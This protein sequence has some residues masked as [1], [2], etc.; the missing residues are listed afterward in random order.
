M[1]TTEVGGTDCNLPC[2]KFVDVVKRLLK[3][4][5]EKDRFFQSVFPEEFGPA[6]DEA[7]HALIWLF[8][9]RLEKFVPYQTFQQFACVLG[10][11]PSVLE[12][13]VQSV[14][15]CEELRS[16]LQYQRNLI[17]LDHHD[18]VSDGACIISALKLPPVRPSPQIQGQ[19]LWLEDFQLHMSNLDKKSVSVPHKAP[20][21]PAIASEL[22]TSESG[23]DACIC[24]P[25]QQ[26]CSGN[27]KIEQTQ[28]N[29]QSEDTLQCALKECKIQL[30]RIDTPQFR[31][32]HPV[33]P[34]R[35]LKMKLLL[36]EEK[37][38]LEDEQGQASGTT[39]GDEAEEES[40]NVD[41]MSPCSEDSWSIYSDQNS[42]DKS[43]R[44]RSSTADSSWSYYS[45]DDSSFVSPASPC[46]SEDHFRD[47]KKTS[48]TSRKPELPNN[49]F[50]ASKKTRRFHCFI[51]N[52]TLTTKLETHLKTHFPSGDYACPHCDA[53]FHLYRGLQKHLKSA[54]YNFYSYKISQDTPEKPGD[55]YKCNEC[56]HAF[57]YKVSLQRHVRTHHELYCAVCQ[58]VLR[59]A[60]AL[61]RHKVSHM[62]FQ[63]NHCSQSFTL[64]KHLLKH[65]ENVHKFKKPYQCYRCSMTVASIRRLII[66]EWKHTGHL[67]FQCTQCGLRCRSDAD[68]IDHSRVHTRERPYLCAECGKTFSQRTNM[69][70]HF[71][72]IHGESR[73][74]R[75]HACSQCEKSFKE[76]GS[77]KKHQRTKHLKELF[78]NPCPYCGKMISTSTMARHKL[79]HTG[80]KP[81]KCDQ[82]DKAFRSNPE[83]KKHKLMCHTLERPYKCDVCGKG[84]IKMWCLKQHTKIHSGE[85]PFVCNICGRAF[86]KCSSMVRHKRLLHTFKVQ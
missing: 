77:L 9:S 3:D 24:E 31:P 76:K 78:H 15:Q 48:A 33:R 82:C 63:C 5:A 61:A 28:N 17:T 71:N 72:L 34:N 41:F 68:L 29:V 40:D 53:R 42:G 73:N 4:P 81:F 12:E 44:S 43:F 32:S 84:F 8:L 57:K 55:I 37:R 26:L 67:P 60:E 80:E 62:P 19:D 85:K 56:T 58:K 16:L 14:S 27:I 18:L 21:T 65:C 10:E 23:M 38:L 54:C 70:R 11:A 25:E 50:P 83:V 52:A 20:V 13:C 64:F 66:H 49:T 51:C 36:Q 79:I 30:I 69:L 74:E 47:R 39:A 7:L 22:L 45:D 35:G 46:P 6:F 2:P 86:L 75:K 59:D 1:W